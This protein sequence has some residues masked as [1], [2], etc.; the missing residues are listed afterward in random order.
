MYKTI[1]FTGLSDQLGAAERDRVLAAM[2]LHVAARA[3]G[4]SVHEV[5]SK[6]RSSARAARARQIAIYLASAALDWTCDRISLAFT[7]TRS[8]VSHACHRVEDLREDAAFDDALSAYE[9]WV[10]SGGALFSGPL[11]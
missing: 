7:R 3:T 10:R 8:T 6:K 11:L 5:T 9:D 2:L 1:D 4:A